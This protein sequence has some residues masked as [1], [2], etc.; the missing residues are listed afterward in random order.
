M[1]GFLGFL[2]VVAGG[3]LSGTLSYGTYGTLREKGYG[4]W[5]AGAATGAIG[6]IIAGGLAWI[7]ASVFPGM[8]ER[9]QLTNPDGYSGLAG[10]VYQSDWA[11]ITMQPSVAGIVAQQLSGLSIQQIKGLDVQLGGYAVDP[12]SGQLIG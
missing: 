9:M 3:A 12:V 4:P 6:G 5:G 10:S 8:L 7:G 11:G 1:M 2:T